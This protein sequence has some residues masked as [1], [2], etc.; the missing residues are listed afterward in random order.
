VVPTFCCCPAQNAEVF[1]LTYG[2][3]V[4]QLI[5]DFEDIEEVNKQLEQM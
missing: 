3:I 2:S 5:S 1:T 4:R